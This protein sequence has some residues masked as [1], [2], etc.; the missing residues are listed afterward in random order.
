MGISC[1]AA[2]LCLSPVSLHILHP[3]FCRTYRLTVTRSCLL[4]DAV[5][6]PGGDPAD[7]YDDARDV[8]D[9]GEDAVPGQGEWEMPRM[10]EE[11]AGCRDAPR[12]E[13]ERQRCLFLGCHPWCPPSHY[14]TD[15]QMSWEGETYPGSFP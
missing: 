14:C 1:D 13:R 6:L 7:G 15:T 8:S 4:S 12:G 11:G 5:V 2:N 9:L 10:P 3:L